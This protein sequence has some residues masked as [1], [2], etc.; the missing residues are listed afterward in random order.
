M[1]GG[2]SICL[3]KQDPSAYMMIH[4]LLVQT[5]QLQLQSILICLVNVTLTA[6]T[7]LH[8]SQFSRRMVVAVYY[9]VVGLEK[10]WQRTE[11]RETNYR[12]PSIAIL[13]EC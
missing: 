6:K 12:G 11:N 4:I 10:I 3:R 7:S 2:I 9:T 8:I 1:L 13:M 5:L